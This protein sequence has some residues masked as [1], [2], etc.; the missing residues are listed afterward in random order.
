MEQG[1]AIKFC[2]KLKKA[3][4]ETSVMLKSIYMKN[5]YLEEECLNGIN[6]SKE[7]LRN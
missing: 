1:A 3:A 5:V 7:V 2:V 4:A 6:G